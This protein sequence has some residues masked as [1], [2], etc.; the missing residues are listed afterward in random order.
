MKG[1][2]EM[3]D[4]KLLT[5]LIEDAVDKGATTVEEIH[6]AIADLPVNMLERLGLF[7]EAASEVKRIQDVSIGSIYDLVR[8]VNHKVAKLAGELI[9]Q[10]KVD[11]RDDASDA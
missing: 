3:S 10:G 6:H 5:E 11:R 4:E 8:D 2:S 7:Q 9:E 1:A